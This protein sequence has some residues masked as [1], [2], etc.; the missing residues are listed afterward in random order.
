[1]PRRVR[2]PSLSPARDP[3]DYVFFSG[4]VSRWIWRVYTQRFTPAGRWFALASGVF[5]MY[6]SVSLQLQGYVLVAYAAG[7]WT[8]AGTAMLLY[9]PRVELRVSAP[10]AVY[11]D[12]PFAVD[13]LVRQRSRFRGADLVVVPNR[14]PLEIRCGQEDGLPLPDL[15]RNGS[16]AASFPMACPRRGTYLLKGFRVETGFPFGMLRARQTFREQRPLLV[17]PKFTPI[18]RLILGAPRRQPVGGVAI[19]ARGGESMEYLGN[20]DYR[21]G[22]NVRDIDWRATARSDRP[23]VREWIDEHVLRAVVLLDTQ[24]DV[25]ERG[26]WKLPWR[27]AT[28]APGEAFEAACSLA[29]AVAEALLRQDYRIDALVIAHAVHEMPTLGSPLHAVL[30]RLALVRP[31]APTAGVD[32]FAPAA[33]A[34]RPLLDPLSVIVCVLLDWDVPRRAL[35]AALA[36]RGLAVKALIVRDLPCTLDPSAD[37]VG[38][39]SINVITPAAVQVGLG[40]L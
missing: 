21:P 37:S 36:E 14:L 33:T 8:V 9:R 2:A 23:V 19:S 35:V 38:T 20:R 4:G 22:D 34:I 31:I 30:E 6:G 40:A 28:P 17:Y 13:L 25:A 32:A 39:I 10:G 1:M 3:G 5:V 18:D 11:A 15:R 26:R 24:L 29:A 12:Q 27:A 7:L 16:A